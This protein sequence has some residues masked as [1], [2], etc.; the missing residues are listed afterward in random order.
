MQQ[1]ATGFHSP[2]LPRDTL[3][4]AHQGEQVDIEEPGSGGGGGGGGDTI[5]NVNFNGPVADVKQVGQIA[6]DAV[7]R[8]MNKRRN[9]GGLNTEINRAVT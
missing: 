1:A 9:A 7:T 4:Q 8:G 3:I 6:L 5:I 2:S